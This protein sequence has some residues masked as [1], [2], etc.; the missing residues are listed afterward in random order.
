MP[1]GEFARSLA[2]LG[3]ITGVMFQAIFMA[4]LVGLYAPGAGKAT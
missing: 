3:A 1:L 4:R 2:I